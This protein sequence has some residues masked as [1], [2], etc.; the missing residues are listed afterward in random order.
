MNNRIQAP[1]AQQPAHTILIVDDDAVNR[2]I[3]GRIFSPY[4]TVEEAENGCEGLEK[5][6]AGPEH[7]CAVLLDVLMP[8][9][10]GIEV[11]RQLR[12]RALPGTLPVFLITAEQSNDVV[13]EAY[14]LGVMDVLYK[15]VI[16]YVVLRRVRSVIELFEARK[17]LGRVAERQSLALQKQSEEIAQL[18]EG[19][20]EAMAIAIESRGEE[21]S[22]HVQRIR[23]ITRILLRD[24]DFAGDIPE[25]EIE[26]IALAAILHDVGKITIPDTV[27]KKP[28][29]LTPEE[30]KVME[31]HTLNGEA[32]LEN[33]PQLRRSETYEYACD[34]V[35]HHHERWDGKGY[36][37]GLAGDE[38]S[39]WAQVVSLADVYDALS[40]KRVYKPPFPREKVR[41]T[42]LTGQCGAFNPRLLE[43]F[44]AVEDRLYALYSDLPETLLDE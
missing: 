4:Y 39:P 38:I 9:L 33:I 31:G 2:K 27:L 17:H 13:Q 3:L 34:I 5:I 14:G 16:P 24:T 26:N 1:A 8:G 28:G 21:H 10:S 18:N 41:E 19:M 44:L 36:P 11:L 6:L 12:E 7:F 25:K 37:D 32:I 30:R 29:K 40:C 42:I 22:G 15:P 35:R 20:L 43:G 23:S